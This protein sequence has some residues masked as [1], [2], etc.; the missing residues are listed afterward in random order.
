MNIPDPIRAAFEKKGDL[1]ISLSGCKDSTATY[2]Y[3]LE[4]GVIDLVHKHGGRV[5]KIFADTGW[6]LPPTYEYLLEMEERIG[7]IEWLA[8]WVPSVGEERPSGYRARSYDF[9]APLWATERGGDGGFMHA[10]RYAVAKRFEERLGH[11]S[12]LVRLIFERRKIPT[13]ARRWCTDDTKKRPIK[14]YL[15][16]CSHPVNTIGVR[17]EESSARALM[18]EWEDS[19]GP[20]G[21]DALVWRPIHHLRYDDVIALHTRHGVAPNPA[22][23]KGVGAGRVGCGPCV[24]SGADD[25]R[26]L[27]ANHPD[28]LALLADLEVALAE[29]DP[30][31]AQQGLNSP[32]WFTKNYRG[33]QY[34][35]P[36]AEAVRLAS[37]DL[38]GDQGLLFV[39]EHKRGCA[40]WGLCGN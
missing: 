22:Y 1:V 4:N 9:M 20:D 21:Y 18:P 16:E 36:V 15:A 10:E 38:G 17:A 35:I 26:W 24:Y 31:R 3:L 13:T 29:L 33:G 19:T 14:G 6:E 7:H 8:T 30:P 27:A 25:I 37:D 39:P 11:Y 2:L 32:R 40:R 28:R 23:I 5:V 34:Q 12:A